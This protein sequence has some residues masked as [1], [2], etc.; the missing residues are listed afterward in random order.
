MS[1]AEVEAPESVPDATTSRRGFLAGAAGLTGVALAVTGWEPVF[2]TG[3]AGLIAGTDAPITADKRGTFV[4]R[5]ALLFDEDALGG[6]VQSAEGGQATSD[7][8]NEKVGADHLI[9]KHLAGVKYEDITINCGTGMSKAFYDWVK[10]TYSCDLQ[11]KS[12]AVV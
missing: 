7:V 5:I 1:E 6:F 3:Q 4:S 8:V 2:A 11:R 9:H 10:G 12:G